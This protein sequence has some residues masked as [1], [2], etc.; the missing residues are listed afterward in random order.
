VR[1]EG[2]VRRGKRVS[3]RRDRGKEDE[4]GEEERGVLEVVKLRKQSTH[5]RQHATH[6]GIPVGWWHCCAV[7]VLVNIPMSE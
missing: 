5:D 2:L 1:G 4:E 3:K 7:L 6:S